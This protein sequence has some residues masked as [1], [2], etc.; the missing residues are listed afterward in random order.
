MNCRLHG[1]SATMQIERIPLNQNGKVNRR[2]LPRIQLQ[3]EEL[4]RPETKKK[5][6][7]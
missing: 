6:P 3:A 4:S 2:E 1:A 7:F 5:R